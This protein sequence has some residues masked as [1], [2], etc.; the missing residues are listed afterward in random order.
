MNERTI[1]QYDI[2][3]LKD[4]LVKLASF[5]SAFLLAASKNEYLFKVSVLELSNKLKEVLAHLDNNIE[6]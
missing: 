6:L 3:N 2:D 5:D 1:S 4:V